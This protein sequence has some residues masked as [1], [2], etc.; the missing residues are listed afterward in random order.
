MNITLYGYIIPDTV[1]KD[2]AT[3]GKKQFFSKSIISIGTEVV[4]NVNNPRAGEL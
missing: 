2:M 4:A 1:N 3:N